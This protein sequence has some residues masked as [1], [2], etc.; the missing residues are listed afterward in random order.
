MLEAHLGAFAYERDTTPIVTPHELRALQEHVASVSVA[1]ALREYLVDLATATRSHRKV[2]L[3]L[4]PRGLLTWQRVSQARAHLQ[5]RDFVMPDD[6]QEVAHSV[7]SVRLSNDHGDTEGI[8]REIV[9][10]VTV[11]V[12]TK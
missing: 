2:K 11:P 3:G 12:F 8:V 6:I 5:G 7:L 10:S 9:D 1:P 4:S